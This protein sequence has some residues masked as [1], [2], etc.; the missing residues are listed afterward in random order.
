[1]IRKGLLLP[2]LAAGALM[3][4]AEA[5][6]SVKLNAT[7]GII[8]Q[9]HNSSQF[10]SNNFGFNICN[11]SGCQTL[12]T[13]VSGLHGLNGNLGGFNSWANTGS[14]SSSGGYFDN[15]KFTFS[16]VGSY[17]G[18]KQTSAPLNDEPPVSTFESVSGAVPEPGTWGM[19]I[20]GF[21]LVGL[22]MRRRARAANFA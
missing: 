19:M 14:Y 6:A 2:V 3:T 7:S 13:G 16:G 8:N 15:Y 4:A 9:L 10:S 1:M 17:F 18:N 12:F 5:Q 20:F 21:G 22:T 11:G